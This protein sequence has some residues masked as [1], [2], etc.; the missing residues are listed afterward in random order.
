MFQRFVA[1][2][3]G[4]CIVAASC[5]SPNKTGNADA[6]FQ[7]VPAN[8]TGIDFNN[9][10]TDTKDFNIFS[11]RNFY[12]GAGVAVG[13]VNNDGLPDIFYSTSIKATGNLRM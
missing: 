2:A 11:Y 9:Q 7:L 13:D 12:N 4:G 8:Q 6:L 5:H 1:I 10:V 3:I